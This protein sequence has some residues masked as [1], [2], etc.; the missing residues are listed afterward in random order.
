MR[1]KGFRVF[2]LFC[3]AFGKIGKRLKRTG[4]YGQKLRKRNDLLTKRT[5]RPV[6]RV[7]LSKNR[8]KLPNCSRQPLKRIGKSLARPLQRFRVLVLR[9]RRFSREADE[10]P[11]SISNIPYFVDIVSEF[12]LSPRKNVSES[13]RNRTL[14]RLRRPT[15]RA[16]ADKGSDLRRSDRARR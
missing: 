13:A 11:C 2:F 3:M 14:G 10:F 16:S 8:G 5:Q 1:E 12:K 7:K 15:S 9:V 6:Y 4:T